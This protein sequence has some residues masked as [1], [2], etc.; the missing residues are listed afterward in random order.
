MSDSPELWDGRWV[1]CRAPTLARATEP[2]DGD[3][4]STNG[5]DSAAIV[6]L[7]HLPPAAQPPVVALVGDLSRAVDAQLA[8]PL[9]AG[10]H[11]LLTVRGDPAH[12]EVLVRGAGERPD[13]HPGDPL[14]AVLNDGRRIELAGVAAGIIDPD[15]TT[16]SISPALAEL[17]GAPAR[18]LAARGLV[19]VIAPEDRARV[20]EVARRVDDIADGVRL[21][22]HDGGPPRWVT[23]RGLDVQPDP[24][25]IADPAPTDHGR[26][27]LVTE[28]HARSGELARAAHRATS[29]FQQA[30]SGRARVDRE[31]HVVAVNPALARM[32]ALDAAVIVGHHLTDLVAPDERPAL[33]ALLAAVLRGDLSELDHEVRLVSSLTPAN[34]ADDRP[35]EG[36]ARWVRL[37]VQAVAL[38]GRDPEVDVEIHDVTNRRRA[39]TMDRDAL[40]A[41]RAAF[42]HAPTPM[43]VIEL[44]GTIGE[45]NS[46]LRAML[47]VGDLDSAPI[48]LAD[49]APEEDRD[50]VAAVLAE[51]ALGGRARVECRLR[52]HDGTERVVE[53]AV[54][55]VTAPDHHSPFA[56]AQVHD[57]TARRDTEEKLLHQTLHDPLTGLGNR[58]LLRDR[59]E[60]AIAQREE[61]PFALMFL[62]LDHFK[63]T[64]DTHGHEAGDELLIEIARRLRTAVR[65]DDTVV[66]LGGDEFVVLAVGVSD[67]AGA[68]V[69][70]GKVRSSIAEPFSVA[71]HLLTVTASVGVVL[72]GAEHD[73]ADA[74][75]RDADLS[76]YRA[77]SSG[78]DRHEVTVGGAVEPRTAPV[79]E[80]LRLALDTDSLKLHHQPIV[81]LRTGRAVG[82][83]ALLRVEDPV[84]GLRPPDRLLDGVTDAELLVDLAG[85]V[86]DSMIG[87]MAGWDEAGIGPLG[88]WIN[89]TGAE[90]RTDSLLERVSATLTRT[91]VDPTRIHVE[92]PEPELLLADGQALERLR[93]LAALGVQLGIDDFGTGTTSLAHLRSLPMTFLKIDPSIGRRLREPGGRAVVEAVV[94]VGRALGLEVIAEGIEDQG[95]MEALAQLGCTHAQG[96]LFA[97]PAPAD[98]LT[99]PGGH[100]GG[101][102][103]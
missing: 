48:R 16:S 59:L 99:L 98:Q 45:A 95:Q 15:G 3:P 81:D 36:P 1:V 47:D 100:N 63:W 13:S 54:A 86:L 62:D 92:I 84:T 28:L 43:A 53:L 37:Q 61:S 6:G 12:I 33:T 11:A 23:V 4:A 77:K 17:A 90:L 19:A 40:E 9:P 83:E 79:A 41:L 60:R 26:L 69:L 35:D 64:N 67:P 71:G 20:L 49:L 42:I 21:D 72:A 5:D 32:F 85:W 102:R 103:T 10:G 30:A 56:I 38:A 76:M 44:D 93:T 25:S 66:R 31:G 88:V 75:L 80:A 22:P 50:L 2:N 18:T 8:L 94:A 97:A 89:L 70:A 55:A 52:R 87:Q 7:E 57:V 74:L 96:N 46:E 34:G 65:A 27:L 39:E 73:T 58:L 91:G 24:T 14:V 29:A 78:R 82:T 68:D 51:I 101:G